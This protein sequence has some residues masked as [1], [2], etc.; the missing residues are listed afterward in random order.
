MRILLV[1]DHPLF[2]QALAATVSQSRSGMVIEQHETVAAVRESLAKDDS[3]ALVLLDLKLS[4]SSGVSGLLSLKARFPDVPVAVVS[5]TDDPETI[6]TAI[7]CGAAGFISKSAGI[8]ELT[9]AV[10]TL[11]QGHTWCP[12]VPGEGEA[13]PLSNTQARILDGVH[14]GLMNKQIAWELGLSEA[15]VK[16]HLTHIYRRMGVITRAQ[17]IA[18]GREKG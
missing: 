13:S 17:L 1:D 7:A 16:Y 18:R 9:A 14:R 15:T 5:A 4:D 3:P 2:R 6:H 8:E 10:E 12:D 11:A